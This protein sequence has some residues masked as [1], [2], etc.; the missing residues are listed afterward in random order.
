MNEKQRREITDRHI[1]ECAEK[2][3]V[4]GR[5]QSICMSGEEW[6]EEFRW[7]RDG[8]K[9]VQYDYRTPEPDSELFTCIKPTLEAC[10]QA[11]DEWLGERVGMQC[12]Q[13]P[14]K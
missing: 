6:Y 10:R 5:S 9:A 7:A 12:H 2:G 13:E 11:R 8:K 1:K 14:G 3:L 4:P